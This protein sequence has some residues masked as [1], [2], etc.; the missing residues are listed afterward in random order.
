MARK[1]E[2][3]REDINKARIMNSARKLFLQNG[4]EQTS[5]EEI[6]SEAGICKATLYTYYPNKSM[7]FNDILLEGMTSLENI[8]EERLNTG[9]TMR[10]SFMNICWSMA[11]FR[12]RAPLAFS[13]VLTQ[14]AVDDESLRKDMTLRR[15][16][17]TGEAINKQ[18]INVFIPAFSGMDKKETVEIVMQIWSEISGLI[19][20]SYNKEKYISKAT[21]KSRKQFLT[22]G[23]DMLYNQLERCISG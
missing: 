12:E 21:G 9:D 4:S 2:P 14:I 11:D 8:F 3:E 10:D 23:F 15:I 7:I 5:M 6:A 20:L 17:E 16:Y 19:T 13:A 18:V 1:K 22:D